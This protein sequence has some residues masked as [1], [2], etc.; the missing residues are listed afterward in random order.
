MAEIKIIEGYGLHYEC[1]ECGAKVEL[2]QKLL[3]GLRRTA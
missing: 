2:G 3:P 1:P